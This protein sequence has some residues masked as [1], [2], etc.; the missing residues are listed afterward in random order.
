MQIL[1]I[2]FF[3]YFP[4]LFCHFIY[5]SACMCS[6]YVCLN[7]LFGLWISMH[8]E[9]SETII[10]LFN[11]FVF[12]IL[13]YLVVCCSGYVYYM[14]GYIWVLAFCF[15]VV[16]ILVSPFTHLYLKMAFC[17]DQFRQTTNILNRYLLYFL[18]FCSVLLNTLFSWV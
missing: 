14:Y 8:G 18:S 4:L 13:R 16:L 17:S 15:T 12:N 3:S 7:T 11:D 6:G 2:H 5:F 9:F 1:F 10:V